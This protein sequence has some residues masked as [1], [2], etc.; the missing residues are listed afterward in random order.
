MDKI[1]KSE[2]KT[3]KSSYLCGARKT[4]YGMFAIKNIPTG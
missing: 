3:L 2:K 4:I 1:S